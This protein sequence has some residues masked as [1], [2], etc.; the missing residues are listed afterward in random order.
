MAGIEGYEQYFLIE[1]LNSSL[2]DYCASINLS[3]FTFAVFLLD[4]ATLR[5]NSLNSIKSAVEAGLTVVLQLP[6]LW[7]LSNYELMGLNP[8]NHTNRAEWKGITEVKVLNG[9]YFA[10]NISTGDNFN[11]Y[12][13]GTFAIDLSNSTQVLIDVVDASM[14]SSDKHLGIF[15]HP[16]DSGT[17]FTV[18]VALS[19]GNNDFKAAFI[20][21]IKFLFQDEGIVPSNAN[22]NPIN[23]VKSPNFSIPTEALVI[24]ALAVGGVA[25]TIG[26]QTVMS[27]KEEEIVGDENTSSTDGS[28]YPRS[29][30]TWASLVIVPI[31][32]IL[33]GILKP[34]IRKLS[35][36]DVH[37]NPTRRKVIEILEEV[38]FEH[39]RELKRLTEAGIGSLTWHLRVLR[40]FGIVEV[41]RY[42]QYK[43]YQLRD[44]QPSKKEIETYF[45]LRSDNAQKIM[46]YFLKHKSKKVAFSQL[47]N[48]LS[49][50]S[51][52][53]HYHCS[54]FVGKRF[55]NFEDD[56]YSL[57]TVYLPEITSALDHL[58]YNRYYQANGF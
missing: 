28:T 16:I 30:F 33:H 43:L 36:E 44:N 35:R 18:N 17:A 5:N 11:L 32:F 8:L 41:E 20:S 31:V 42:G 3:Q 26:V 39:F 9:S 56:Y 51:D 38:K 2:D 57:N 7:K 40:D 19:K 10:G 52:T 29:D 23:T 21:L 53:I 34:E 25:T 6:Q 46:K 14:I 47:E 27:K 48:D 45:A 55:L 1:K 15:R 4:N 54:K 13:K 58:V 24:S 22:S 50:N 49:I 12:G 37:D